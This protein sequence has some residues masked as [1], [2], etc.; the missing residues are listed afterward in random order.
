MDEKN[1]SGTSNEI[2]EDLDSVQCKQSGQ[3]IESDQRRKAV[4]NILAGSG[5]TLGAA[6]TGSW[7]KPVVNAVIL[8]SHAQMSAPATTPAPTPIMLAGNA[9]VSPVVGIDPAQLPRS[10]SVL[11]FFIGPANAGVAG[12]EI[13]PSGACMT[14]TVPGD[15]TF[16][17]NVELASSTAVLI[18][19]TISAGSISGAG[20]GLTVSGTIDLAAATP[21][22]MGTITDGTSSYSFTIDGATSG[23]MPIATTAAPTSTTPEPRTTTTTTSGPT[24]SSTPAPPTSP[25]M[26]TS[27]TPAPT[28]QEPPPTTTQEPE[29]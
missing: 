12:D 24:T 19:G 15:G 25:R 14:M 2:S 5:L 23:C 27:S 8:P 20:G 17:L 29:V 6:T 1:K 11:D 28:T 21:V 3:A 26:T 9:S 16:T 13:S 7:V 22:A 4:R 10:S 18:S